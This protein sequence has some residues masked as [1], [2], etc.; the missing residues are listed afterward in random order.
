MWS[1]GKWAYSLPSGDQVQNSRKVDFIFALR[2]SASTYCLS[3][4]FAET[5]KKGRV[6]KLSRMFIFCI[7]ISLQH[8]E[9]NCVAGSL[10]EK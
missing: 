9:Y 2:L 7:I 3:T 10:K 6:A 8:I 1:R 5:L 4:R